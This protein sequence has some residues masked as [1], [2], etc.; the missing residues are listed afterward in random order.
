MPQFTQSG[1]GE[2]DFWLIDGSSDFAVIPANIIPEI[3]ES[4]PIRLQNGHAGFGALHI[5]KR[6]GHWVLKNEP[7]GCVATITH[8]KLSQ[9][10]TLYS[11]EEKGKLSI[12]MRMAPQAFMV[13]RHEKTF[14]TV[15][16]L[17]FKQ[18]AIDGSKIGRYLGGEWARNPVRATPL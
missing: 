8:R 11:T 13:L 5:K 18:S 15:V 4:T 6:H 9:V 3:T 7:S 17:Y 12:A 10:G 1:S 2:Y 14:F 16:T